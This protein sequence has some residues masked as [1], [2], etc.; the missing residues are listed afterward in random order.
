[1]VNYLENSLNTCIYFYPRAKLK[2]CN[3]LGLPEHRKYHVFRNIAKFFAASLAAWH[4]V[5][6]SS[7]L[8]PPSQPNLAAL[9]WKIMSSGR[10]RMSSFQWKFYFYLL[11]CFEYGKSE[12]DCTWWH[13]GLRRRVWSFSILCNS[14]G[15][16]FLTDKLCNTVT[17]CDNSNSNFHT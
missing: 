11:T 17:I 3:R 12:K 13:W 4:S 7:F 10:L 15:C 5:S 6:W 2:F 9:G 8:G 14:W 16:F 1:M